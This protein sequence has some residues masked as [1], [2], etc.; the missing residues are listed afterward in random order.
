MKSE[1]LTDRW[2][3]ESSNELIKGENMKNQFLIHTH[4]GI[5]PPSLVRLLC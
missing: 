5:L 1:K 3:K 4:G 2:T